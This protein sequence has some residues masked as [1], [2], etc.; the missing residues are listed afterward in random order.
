MWGLGNSPSPGKTFSSALRCSSL[1]SL[2]SGRF[3][4]NP[5]SCL[6]AWR[7]CSH[8]RLL[9]SCPPTC[10]RFVRLKYQSA[11][12]HV[13]RTID[14]HW[15]GQLFD[16]LSLCFFLTTC[17]FHDVEWKS[18]TLRRMRT[19]LHSLLRLLLLL[20]LVVVVVVVYKHLNALTH[21]R[22]H[23]RTYAHPYHFG[24]DPQP[25]RCHQGYNPQLPSHVLPVCRAGMHSCACHPGRM[26][27]DVFPIHWSC[28]P[29][30]P[31][32]RLVLALRVERKS[33]ADL[34]F[35]E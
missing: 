9:P 14:E 24:A 19:K 3:H 4:I 22:T 17:G 27:V 5:M 16:V 20:L 30:T 11:F 28:Q 25:V 2:C 21:A 13:Q 35:N 29:V 33:H 34:E 32:D 8:A 7:S 18:C 31:K 15:H 26:F 10:V 12:A 23:A 1:P 6:M